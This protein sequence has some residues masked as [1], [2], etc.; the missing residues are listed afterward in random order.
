MNKINEFDNGFTAGMLVTTKDIATLIHRFE[1]ELLSKE[2]MIEILKG[3]VNL[4]IECYITSNRRNLSSYTYNNWV[5]T[6]DVIIEPIK[7]YLKD[8]CVFND[9]D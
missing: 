5:E 2:E 9:K 4:G 1:N 6:N 7:K 8:K 3:S